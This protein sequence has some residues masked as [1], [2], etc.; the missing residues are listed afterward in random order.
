MTQE[1]IKAIAVE[2]AKE[3]IEQL[4]KPKP[5][6]MTSKREQE[7][8]ENRAILLRAQARYLKKQMNQSK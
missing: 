5:K 4:T 7:K 6:V 2:V 1:E 8:A 3:V